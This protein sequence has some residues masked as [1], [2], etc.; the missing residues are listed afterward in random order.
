MRAWAPLFLTRSRTHHEPLAQGGHVSQVLEYKGT[1]PVA[2]NLPWRPSDRRQDMS[3]TKTNNSI[4]SALLGIALASSVAPQALAAKGG[5]G[6]SSAP[7]AE[8]RGAKLL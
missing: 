5:G 6:A 3:S 7:L 1:S 4:L 2:R 8:Q